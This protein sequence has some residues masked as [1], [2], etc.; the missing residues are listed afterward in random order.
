[1]TVDVASSCCSCLVVELVGIWCFSARDGETF[2]F[3]LL[4][5]FL[6]LYCSSDN[7]SVILFM[8]TFE[9]KFEV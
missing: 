4:S 7:S 6:V 3:K 5:Y 8:H 9:I 2:A 1:M